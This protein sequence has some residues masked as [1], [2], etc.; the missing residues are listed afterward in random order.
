[1]AH[2]CGGATVATSD[3]GDADLDTGFGFEG[4][5][6]VRAL[7]QVFVYAGW[8]W[9]RFPS[10][11]SFAG[12]DV[13]F[14]ESGYAFGLLFEHALSDDGGPA[15][16]LRAGGTVNHIEFER[17]VS[18]TVD[19]GHGVGWEA[20]VGLAVPTVGEWRVTP[21]VRFRALSRDIDIETT[22]TAVDLNY[23][24]FEVG[25]SRLF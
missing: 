22:T 6:M 11:P 23:F 18:L 14:E 24:A 15:I 13:D 25:V 1:M 17:G 8:D 9:H 3:L 19:S 20:G 4:T 10:G 16:Q 2:L 7:E 21:G 12:N 5:F